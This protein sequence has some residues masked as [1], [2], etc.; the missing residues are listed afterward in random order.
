MVNASTRSNSLF[1]VKFTGRGPVDVGRKVREY[2][3]MYTKYKLS[4]NTIRSLVETSVQ[5]LHEKGSIIF[6]VLILAYYILDRMHI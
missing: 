3:E 5:G 4:T 2:F 6:H 1:F